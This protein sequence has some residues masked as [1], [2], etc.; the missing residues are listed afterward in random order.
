MKKRGQ[1]SESIIVIG[2]LCISGGFQ[3]A[4]TYIC[5]NGVFANAQTGNIVLMGQHFAEGN[6]KLGLRYLLPV[7]SFLLGIILAEVIKKY[8]KEFDKIHWRQIVLAIEILVL[9]FVGWMPEEMNIAA[10]MF[11]SLV[12]AMQVQSFR[13]LNGNAYATTMCIG[14]LRTATELWFTYHTTGNTKLKKKS[15][16]YFGFIGIFAIGA[17]VGSIMA[18]VFSKRAIWFSCLVLIGAFCLMFIKESQ[19]LPENKNV[20]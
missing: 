12:C 8:Y 14:N 7:F 9:F 6:L 2:L 10:N 18:G 5:R 15:M 4:Y 17:A 20:S 16:L 19:G 11:V 1:M 3:D 13:K